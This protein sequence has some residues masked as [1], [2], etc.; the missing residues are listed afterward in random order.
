MD[1][2]QHLDANSL[3]TVTA[4]IEASLATAAVGSRWQLERVGYFI[5]DQDSNAGAPVLNRI[6]TLRDDRVEVAKPDAAP[7]AEVKKNP[8]AVSRPKGKT[9]QEFR[10]EARARD[11]A[12]NAKY[13]AFVALV[14]DANADLLA[15][16]AETA[17]QFEAVS[18]KVSPALAAKW[19][20]NELPR[21]IDEDETI[22]TVQLTELLVAID[23]GKVSPTLGKTLLQ[24]IASGKAYA[25][26]FASIAT[27]PVV[28][29]G[30]A[31]DAVIKANPDKAAAYKSGKTGLLGFFVG[32]VM[33]ATPNVDAA[34]VNQAVRDRLG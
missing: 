3:E 12:L 24:E 10:A 28:D 11:G 19:M 25:A 33:K 8:K 17:A 14:G 22:D 5:V 9:P 7:K 1:F 20:V 6:I 15:G 30:A 4:K 18:R 31:I 2:L 27:M 26:A 32:Q 29:L 23:S 16:D 13:T 34:Q 21:V